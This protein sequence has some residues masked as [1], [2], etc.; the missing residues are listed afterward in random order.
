MFSQIAP[1]LDRIY[2]ECIKSGVTRF[3]EEQE[4]TRDDVALLLPPQISPS[5]VDEVARQLSFEQSHTV[6]VAIQGHDLFTSSMPVAMQAVR[7][8]HLASTGDLGLIVTVGDG[9]QVGCALYR[10]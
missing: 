3:L 7:E 6:D 5:F 8:R 9:V 4:L 10:F 1:D 2:L